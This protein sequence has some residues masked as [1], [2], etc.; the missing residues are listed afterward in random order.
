[1]ICPCGSGILFDGCCGAILAGKRKAGTAE[2]LMRSR[3]TAYVVKDV[4]YL[5]R[6]THPSTRT[7]SLANSIRLWMEQV[8]WLRLHVLFSGDDTVEFIAE[9]ISDGKPGQHHER[10][11]FKKEKGE[12]FYVGDEHES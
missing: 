10:S 1:M 11:A 3:Y 4:D 2:Q 12:W 8:E 5:V 6:T 7:P 9:Y